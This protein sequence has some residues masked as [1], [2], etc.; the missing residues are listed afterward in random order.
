VSQIPD[1][2]AHIPDGRKGSEVEGAI[3]HGAGDG[4]DPGGGF[5][6]ELHEGIHPLALVLAVEPGL[7]ALNESHRPDQRRKLVRDVF[8]PDSAGL[9]DQPGRFFPSR[10]PEVGEESRAH[11]DR[12]PHI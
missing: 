4:Q 7:P 2:A 1:G 5:P 11:A 6:R 10:S 9:V 8:P 12:L 3:G